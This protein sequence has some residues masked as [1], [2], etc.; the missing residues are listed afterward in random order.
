MKKLKYSILSLSL[1]TTMAGAAVSPALGAIQQN[2]SDTNATLVKMIISLPSL[3]I[4]FSSLGFTHLSKKFSGK[5]LAIVG[6]LLYLIGGL[7]AGLMNDIYLVLI[8]RAVL[9]I[10]VGF[11]MPLSTGLLS[12]YFSKR[13]QPKLLGTASAMNNVGGIISTILASFLVMINWRYVFFVYCLGFIVILFIFLYLPND[14]PVKEEQNGRDKF[15]FT[16]IFPYFILM[17]T[18]MI[19]FYTLPS[20]FSIAATKFGKIPTFFIGITM[21]IQSVSAV[22]TGLFLS[23]IL[24]SLKAFSKYFAGFL[25]FLGY[26]SLSFMDNLFLMVLGLIFIGGGLGILV[27]VINAQIALHIK[28]EQIGVAMSFMSVG[29][30]LGQFLSPLITDFIKELFQVNGTLS[31]FYVTSALALILLLE[32]FIWRSKFSD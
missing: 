10:G 4:I 31:S 14:K 26:V 20:N 32:L 16:M 22:A 3:F 29:M 27:P 30:F 23:R 9:G 12:V 13:E 18:L 21:S 2:F 25:F 5:I 11:L 8:F 7:G 28:R 15:K 17:M 19:V 24:G 1:L 6:L